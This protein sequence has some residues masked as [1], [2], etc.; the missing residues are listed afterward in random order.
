[1]DEPGLLYNVKKTWPWW[2]LLDTTEASACMCFYFYLS[3]SMHQWLATC[4]AL[5]VKC[6]TRW[7]LLNMNGT[8]MVYTHEW[9]NMNGTHAKRLLDR[10]SYRGGAVGPP[11][12]S[13]KVLLW[14]C[15]YMCTCNTQ[16]LLSKYTHLHWLM[17]HESAKNGNESCLK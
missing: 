7:C 10:M 9:Y 1:M 8:W 12:E 5:M 4:I 17:C 15:M 16:I 14:Y 3:S 11:P 6:S 2:Q 13:N